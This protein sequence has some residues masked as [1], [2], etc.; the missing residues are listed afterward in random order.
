[1]LAG[2]NSNTKGLSRGYVSIWHL[3]LKQFRSMRD[4]SFL[5][6]VFPS[7]V[8]MSECN[9]WYLKLLNLIHT[10]TSSG[11]FSVSEVVFYFPGN[12]RYK[13]VKARSA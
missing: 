10:H 13:L 3:S 7:N 2:K 11:F 6:F 5:D 9:S 12:A 4:V 1:M 8:C